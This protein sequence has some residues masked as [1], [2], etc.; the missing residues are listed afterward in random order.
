MYIWMF[1]LKYFVVDEVDEFFD[2]FF[3]FVVDIEL[4]N[5]KG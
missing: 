3:I 1:E 2:I 4:F 5:Y